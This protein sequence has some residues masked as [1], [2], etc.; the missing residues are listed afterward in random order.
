MKIYEITTHDPD[1]AESKQTL[2]QMIADSRTNQNHCSVSYTIEF[3]K[4]MSS[5]RETWK[6]IF[7]DMV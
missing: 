3:D 4:K 2:D 1:F 7:Y 6:Y 5:E